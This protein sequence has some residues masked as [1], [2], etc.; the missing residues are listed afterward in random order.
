MLPQQTTAKKAE[1]NRAKNDASEL[2]AKK[3]SKQLKELQKARSPDQEDAEVDLEAD[4]DANVHARKRLCKRAWK[5][6]PKNWIEVA[7]YYNEHGRDATEKAFPAIFKDSTAHANYQRL[8]SW[9]KD[10]QINKTVC[11]SRRQSVL[12]KEFESILLEQLE[13]RKAQGL[14]INADV[15]RTLL[16]TQLVKSDLTHLMRGHGGVNTFGQAWCT[17]F[18]KRHNLIT[19]RRRGPRKEEV[20]V[21]V[22]V[23]ALPVVSVPA[24]ANRSLD[25]DTVSKMKVCELRDALSSRGLDSSGVKMDLIF[26]LI[27]AFNL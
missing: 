16:V 5:S 26:R 27:D 9:K 23:E 15:L 1:P 2:A 24:P 22:D 14:V 12:G 10:L 19:S 11:D 21:D 25:R 13:S 4:E 3:K 8:A 18:W 17:R 7:K 20:E 6:R